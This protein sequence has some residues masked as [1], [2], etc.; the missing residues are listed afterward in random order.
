MSHALALRSDVSLSLP[1]SGAVLAVPFAAAEL[2]E[3]WLVGKDDKTVRA[4]R[5]DLG[6]FR[7]FLASV[8]PV[9][10]PLETFLAL[11]AA[12]AHVTVTR[13]VAWCKDAGHAPAT[14]NRRL[15]ALRSVVAFARMAGRVTWA[16]EVK[17]VPTT[18]YRD[19]RGPGVSNVRRLLA[20]LEHDTTAK[21]RRDYAL[22]RCLFDLALRRA[23]AVSLDLV[24][25][26]LEGK[27]VAI[28]GKKRSE[29]AWYTLPAPTLAAL[30][31]W[32]VV[33]GDAPGPL[34]LN[35]D[36]AGKGSRLT[37]RSVARVLA[38]LGDVAGVGLVRPHGLRHSAITHAL[39]TFGDIRR[40][41]RFSRHHDI[42]T[43]QVYDDNRTD[44][45]GEVASAVASAV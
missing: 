1:A 2:L 10:D 37:G 43:L 25:L 44:L 23:E 6:T 24:H 32:L 33:R 38:R 34:F 17:G 36:R 41:A 13:F 20:S 45:F 30:E 35:F 11:D 31:A 21:G 27:R 7:S 18:A 3:T 22:V 9:G 16:L 5:A 39:N 8:A 40:A 14:I 12:S 42:R 4:Y 26:D 19:T 29:R 28:L 15:A